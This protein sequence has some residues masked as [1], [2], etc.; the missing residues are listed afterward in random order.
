MDEIIEE[1]KGIEGLELEVCGSWLWISG[2]TKEHK[3][4]LKSLG[5]FYASKKQKWYFRPAE[6]KSRRH[7]PV[8][9]DRIRLLHGSE[10]IA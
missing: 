8:N 4:L 5:L 2:K 6:Y 1:L 9:M 3:E 10:V 7:R